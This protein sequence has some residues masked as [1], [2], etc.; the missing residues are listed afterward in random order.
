ME[1]SFPGHSMVAHWAYKSRTP[2]S[3]LV[4][5]LLNNCLLAGFWL[6]CKTLNCYPYLEDSFICHP[7]CSAAWFQPGSSTLMRSLAISTLLLAVSYCK[8]SQALAPL[9]ALSSPQACPLNLCF[10][11]SSPSFGG[12]CFLHFC[13]S[14][15]L[16]IFQIL[17]HYC[18][19]RTI[20]HISMRY[21]TPCCK[22][23]P[24]KINL[25]NVYLTSQF[26]GPACLLWW[27]RLTEC[28]AAGHIVS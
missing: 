23:K 2:A 4:T 27:G 28:E 14:E 18:L 7:H 5:S 26:K 12:N 21:L 17:L 10:W 9:C 3:L 11:I 22:T 6:L 15:C 24:G 20:L 16:G 13:I 25:R 19:C 8:D 1:G